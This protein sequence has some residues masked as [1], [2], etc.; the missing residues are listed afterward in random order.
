[1]TLRRAAHGER[2]VDERHV[3][4]EERAHEALLHVEL[5]VGEDGDGRALGAG[6]GGGRDGDDRQALALDLVD[7]DVVVHRVA[8]VGQHGGGLGD[9][10]RRAAA[11]AHDEVVAALL[12][13][14]DDLLDGAHG[15]LGDGLVVEGDLEAGVDQR[16]LD[17]DAHAA[18]AHAL[19][20]DDEHLRAVELLGLDAQLVDAR[21][22][23]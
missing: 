8:G 6:A 12:D 22:R 11:E 4:H 20:G 9:V 16:R 13:D 2:R 23:R 17:V 19:V 18:V 21:R 15:R 14:A 1:M 5:L 10:D 7:A 3:G